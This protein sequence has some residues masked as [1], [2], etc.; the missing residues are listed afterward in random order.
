MTL[1]ILTNNVEVDNNLLEKSCE[2][3]YD[4]CVRVENI[5]QE[6]RVYNEIFLILR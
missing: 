6:K 1:T 3:S 4:E 2:A 5:R